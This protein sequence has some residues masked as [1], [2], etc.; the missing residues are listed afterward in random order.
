[1]DVRTCSEGDPDED[2]GNEGGI[3]PVSVELVDQGDE[4]DAKGVGDSVG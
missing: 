3:T 1:M 2:G 4:E